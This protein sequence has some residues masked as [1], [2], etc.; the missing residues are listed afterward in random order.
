MAPGRK[1]W[2]A[3][4][5]AGAAGALL[6]AVNVW[7][8]GGDDDVGDARPRPPADDANT[9]TRL[10]ATP[11]VQGGGSQDATELSRIWITDEAI[12]TVLPTGVT[13]YDPASGEELWRL[14]APE[15]ADHLCDAT[16]DVNGDGIGALAYTPVDDP[17]EDEDQGSESCSVVAAVDAAEGEILWSH[18]LTDPEGFA[19]GELSGSLSIGDEAVVFEMD[20]DEYFFRFAIDGGEELPALDVPGREECGFSEPSH[21]AEYTVLQNHCGLYVYDTDSGEPMRPGPDWPDDDHLIDIMGGEQ[22]VLWGTDRLMVSDEYGNTLIEMPNPPVSGAIVADSVLIVPTTGER[23]Y[24]GWDLDTGQ[25]LWEEELPGSIASSGGPD[26]KV[27]VSYIEDRDDWKVIP[28]YGWLDPRDGSVSDAGALASGN[29]VGP[30]YDL[31]TDDPVVYE[32]AAPRRA[33]EGEAAVRLV[34]YEL[35]G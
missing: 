35:A 7:S 13:A 16:S 33:G 4:L 29:A 3:A 32:L 20:R 31:E 25:L 12:V 15:G 8:G 5:A 24:A 22:L 18:D 23:D 27:L 34:A 6:L 10:W 26:G 14:D 1:L 19:T 30:T 9:L 17:I 11:A 21:T 2:S 28:H